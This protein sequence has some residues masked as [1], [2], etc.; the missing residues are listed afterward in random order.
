MMKRSKL[1]KHLNMFNIIYICDNYMQSQATVP[2]SLHCNTTNIL[3]PLSK[4]ILNL[5]KCKLPEEGY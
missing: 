5:V 2:I 1:S 3:K 4:A